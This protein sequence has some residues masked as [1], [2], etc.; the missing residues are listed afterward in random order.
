MSKKE[1]KLPY[2]VNLDPKTRADM[3]RIAEGSR[4]AKSMA[5]VIRGAI[6]KYSDLLQRQLEAEERGNKLYLVEEAPDR[7]TGGAI[8][9]LDLKL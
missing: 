4:A 2:T 6:W 5:A 3:Q 9:E 1:P 8:L 7:P